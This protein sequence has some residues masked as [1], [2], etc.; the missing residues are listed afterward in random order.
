MGAYGLDDRLPAGADPETLLTLMARDK[1][2]LRGLTF[3]LESGDERRGFAVD[4]V[5]G[6]DPDAVRAALAT[7]SERSRR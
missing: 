1:K 5:D 2:A 6:I 7:M 3:V 4:V